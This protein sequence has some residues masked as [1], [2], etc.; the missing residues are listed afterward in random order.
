MPDSDNA[1]RAPL[2]PPG[3]LITP[4]GISPDK[5]HL[6]DSDGYYRELPADGLTLEMLASLCKRCGARFCFSFRDAPQTPRSASAAQRGLAKGRRLPSRQSEEQEQS[7]T[8]G[9]KG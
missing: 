2:L 5:L 1:R 3:C 4:L 7:R 6:L 9:G 8:Y